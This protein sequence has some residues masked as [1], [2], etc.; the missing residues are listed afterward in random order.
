MSVIDPFDEPPF[1]PADELVVVTGVLRPVEPH[2]SPSFSV[3]GE[4]VEVVLV[5]VDAQL[6]DRHVPGAVPVAEPGLDVIHVVVAVDEERPLRVLVAVRAA[7]F[8]RG[9]LELD[10]VR[11][12]G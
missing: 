12:L 9:L 4:V 1:G 6:T 7:R 8:V 11:V 3:V 2:H 10:L 5:K